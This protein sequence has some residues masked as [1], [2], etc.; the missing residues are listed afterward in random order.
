[1][2]DSISEQIDLEGAFEQARENVKSEMEDIADEGVDEML[3]VIDKRD[4]VATGDLKSSIQRYVELVG[5]GVRARI[6]ADA[7]PG[8]NIAPYAHFVDQPTRPHW[9]PIQPLERWARA[10]FNATGQEKTSIAYGAAWSIARRGTP[11]VRF[12]D[13]AFREIEGDFT[14][15]IESAVAKAFD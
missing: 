13:A 14:E 11:G 5:G 4:A 10:K 12:T 2:A 1:M 8:S 9:P 15:R 6:G 3:R 7:K